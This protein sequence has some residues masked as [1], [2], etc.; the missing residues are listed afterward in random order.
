MAA[1]G[2][3]RTAGAGAAAARMSQPPLLPAS[4]ETRKFTRALSKPGTAAEL[5]QSVSEVVRGSVLLVSA[6]RRAGGHL[7]RAPPSRRAPRRS[8]RPYWIKRWWGSAGSVG[9]GEGRVPEGQQL[10][11]PHQASGG[12]H[13]TAASSL[14]GNF[15]GDCHLPQLPHRPAPQFTLRLPT[16]KLL[17]PIPPI[18]PFS[19][20]I[21]EGLGTCSLEWR[22]GVEVGVLPSSPQPRV[23]DGPADPLGG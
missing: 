3:G 12:P 13:L 20:C 1:A 16:G 5:R 6:G 7:L 4:A 14:S 15:L 22:R 9:R 17:S 10:S 23:G 2:P 19:S 8:R 18:A 11:D 21:L